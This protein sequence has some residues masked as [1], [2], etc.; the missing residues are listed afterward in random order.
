MDEIVPSE[1]LAFLAA[2]E[3]SRICLSL[4]EH[5]KADTAV[6]PWQTTDDLGGDRGESNCVKKLA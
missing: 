2:P 5:G 1:I 3:H 6:I 4:P